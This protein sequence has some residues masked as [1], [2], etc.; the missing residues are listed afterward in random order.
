MLD[1]EYGA[2]A[3]VTGLNIYL[4]SSLELLDKGNVG[5][6]S[7]SLFLCLIFLLKT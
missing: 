2:R 1:K 4:N 6:L 3:W 5:K 7:R